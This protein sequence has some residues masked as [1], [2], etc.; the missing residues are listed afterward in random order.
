MPDPVR[1]AIPA[2]DTLPY[3]RNMGSAGRPEDEWWRCQRVEPVARRAI[4]THFQLGDEDAVG[5]TKEATE[6]TVTVEHFMHDVTAELIMA[7]KD[8]A[9]DIIYNLKDMLDQRQ[10]RVNLVERNTNGVPVREYEYDEGMVSTMTWA[11][12][13]RTPSSVTTELR[14]ILG[15]VYCSGG[16]IPHSGGSLSYPSDDTTS[17][18]AILGKDARVRFG[19]DAAGSRAYR[20]QNFSIRAAIPVDLVRELGRRALVGI[21]NRMPTV[22]ADFDLLTADCQPHSTF[23]DLV[24]GT[25][26]HYDFG[27]SNEVDI[28]VRVYDPDLAEGNTVIRAFKLENADPG[29]VTPMSV[30]VN[31]LAATRYS[32]QLAKPDTAN[33]CG[34]IMYKGDIP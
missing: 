9:V 18:G 7:G 28:F 23:F 20:L 33:T 12:G 24:A 32:V 25:N 16:S 8:P 4:T 14:A 27:Q 17:P 30:N 2:K 13:V 21:M 10:L 6:Y 29:D 34:L 26:P 19:T 31:G 3:I 5:V 11:M 15:K 22:S 1:I